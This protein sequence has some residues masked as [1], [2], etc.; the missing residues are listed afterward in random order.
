MTTCLMKLLNRSECKHKRS[1]QRDEEY[2]LER[3]QDELLV[4]DP[5]GE[6]AVLGGV[7]SDPGR[8][9][10]ERNRHGGDTNPPCQDR[11]RGA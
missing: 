10:F 2:L 1:E 3:A 4:Y 11:W 7:Q 8:P 5:G 9:E 6:M